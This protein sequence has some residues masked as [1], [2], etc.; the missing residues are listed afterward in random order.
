M[1]LSFAH[2]LHV[3]GSTVRK[4]C[5]SVALTNQPASDT[6]KGY[7]LNKILDLFNVSFPFLSGPYFGLTPNCIWPMIH[8]IGISSQL[9]G[10]SVEVWSLNSLS[11][12]NITCEQEKNPRPKFKS[13]VF[14]VHVLTNVMMVVNTCDNQLFSCEHFFLVII[15]CFQLFSLH[16]S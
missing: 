1:S 3:N 2:T 6:K 11:Y 14:S 15:F 13:E 4:V 12:T 8:S 10:T 9:V 5:H 7:Q 16:E